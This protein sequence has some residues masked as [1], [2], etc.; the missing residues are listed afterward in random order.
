MTVKKKLQRESFTFMGK[1]IFLNASHWNRNVLKMDLNVI[2]SVQYD[3]TMGL[4][5]ES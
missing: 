4:R 2:Q 1:F 5:M 3:T